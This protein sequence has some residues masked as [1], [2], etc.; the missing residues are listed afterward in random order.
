VSASTS[1]SVAPPVNRRAAWPEKWTRGKQL[2]AV[3]VDRGA[4][5]RR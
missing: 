4:Q 2:P 1:S 5:P 3:F